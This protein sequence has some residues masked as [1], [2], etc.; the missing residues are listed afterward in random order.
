M[1]A[2]AKLF[3]H[4]GSQA[5]RLPKAF[6]FKGTEVSV[7]KEGDAVILEPIRAKESWDDFFA[8]VDAMRQAASLPDAGHSTGQDGV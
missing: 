5:V 6:R 1:T 8:R 7:R 3:T 4:G 2:T